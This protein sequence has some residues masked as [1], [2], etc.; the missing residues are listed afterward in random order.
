MTTIESSRNN[1]LRALAQEFRVLWTILPKR[2]PACM[3]GHRIGFEV[4]LW[5]THN[6]PIEAG[7]G[8][9]FDCRRVLGVLEEIATLIAPSECVYRETRG[10]PIDSRSHLYP[11]DG[12]GRSIRLVIEVVCIGGSAAVAAQCDAGCLP[13][14]RERLLA[15]GARQI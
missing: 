14:M 10:T 15:I 12:F 7:S 1:D 4:E 3:N 2:L 8:E 6:H 11:R 9:C 5:G 13:G